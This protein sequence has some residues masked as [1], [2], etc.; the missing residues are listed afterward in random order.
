MAHMWNITFEFHRMHST[1]LNADMTIEQSGLCEIFQIGGKAL[2][3]FSFFHHSD[4]EAPPRA[5]QEVRVYLLPFGA[6]L[7][8][9][10]AAAPFALKGGTRKNICQETSW[11]QQLS[12]WKKKPQ[13]AS[14]LKTIPQKVFLLPIT[15][16]CLKQTAGVNQLLEY[17]THLDPQCNIPPPGNTAGN[18]SATKESPSPCWLHNCGAIDLRQVT[19]M[20]YKHQQKPEKP[21]PLVEFHLP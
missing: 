9:L 20:C 17:L 21:D 14:F 1:S 8:M 13:A 7:T 18:S 19:P 5:H 12:S 2:A 11:W 3:L 15:Y 4:H 10:E 16:S 6:H